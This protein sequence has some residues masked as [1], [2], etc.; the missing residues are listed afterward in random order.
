VSKREIL[1][2]LTLKMAVP[3]MVLTGVLIPL[4]HQLIMISAGT[5]MTLEHRLN[6]RKWWDRNRQIC[7]GKAGV[8]LLIIGCSIALAGIL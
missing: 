3:T 8:L 6:Y 5:R 7:H 2:S 4:G 1:K